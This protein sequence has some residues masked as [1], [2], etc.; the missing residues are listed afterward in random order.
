MLTRHPLM[1]YNFPTADTGELP[2][3]FFETGRRHS[4][5]HPIS[6]TAEKGWVMKKKLFGFM[7]LVPALLLMTACDTAFTVGSRTIGIR[8]GEFIY[9]DGYL[10]ATYTFPFAKVWLACEKTLI[11]M[12]AVDVE[13]VKKIATGNL[14]AMI[15]EEKVRI[16]VD[17][18]EKEMTSVSIMAGISGNT[19]ASQLIHDRIANIL[20]NP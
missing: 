9:T 10:R 14:T 17:Y 12:K 3:R 5:C 4:I 6:R 20:E 13:R 15:Q 1:A 11:D 18:V 16:S 7:F 19:L 8:S 2:D